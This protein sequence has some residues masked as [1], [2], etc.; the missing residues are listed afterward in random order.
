MDIQNEKEK[1]Q[2]SGIN[3]LLKSQALQTLMEKWSDGSFEEFMDDWKWIFSYSKRYKKAIIF[4]TLLGI[5][6][7]TLSLGSSVVSKYMID[8]IVGK[9]LDKLWLLALIMVSST[10][11]SLVFSSLVSR[12]STKISIQVGND[13][14]A[15]IFSRIVSADWMALHHYP[16]GDLLNRFNS[17][18]G[19]VSGNAIGWLP[20]VIIHT[21]TFLST[22]AVILY[23]DV[24]MAFI[25]LLSAP[26]LLLAS[27]WVLRKAREYRQRVMEMN[28]KLMTFEVDTFY[29]LDTI[30]SFGVTEKYGRELGKWQEKY[31]HHNLEYNLFSIKTNILTTMISTAVSLAAF[32]YC[33]F[34]L[35]TDAIS[36]GTMTLFLQQR[37]ALSGQFNALVGIVPGM[38]N[39]SVSAHRIREIVD[40]PREELNPEAAAALQDH[41]ADG[42]TV[43]MDG[44]NF[45]YEEHSRVITDSDFIARPGEIV[46]LVGPSGEGKTTMIR[47][48]LGLIHPEGGHVT[49]TGSDG[50]AL[51]VSADLRQFFSYVPQGNTMLAGTVAE[52][53]RMV[54]EDATDEEIIDAL[55]AACAWD[56]VSKLPDNIHSPVGERGRGFSEGQ[57]QRIAIARALLRDAPVMLLDEATSALDVTTERQV[58]KNIIRQ[59]P[60]KTCIVTTHRPSVLNLC[61]RVYRV[62][63][64]QVRELSEAESS[65]M[66]MDF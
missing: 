19:T 8:I 20:N 64:T 5:F 16:N 3:R 53:M 39:S 1:K 15:D 66:A 62:M 21:Y 17:D 57:A 40:L 18:V 30:K 56:F 52:N 41:A 7:S 44:V 65:R 2:Y 14:Q 13:I 28:S 60:N 12:I 6:S 4:Y 35:W 32:G 36:Y 51:D 50:Q 27:R 33:L 61:Q 58:L 34:R 10:V 54:R 43:R 49:L 26:F 47:L 29:N 46:A 11:F 48:I 42:L 22:F 23:Y 55:K 59:H 31:K 37:S 9:Q 45:A 38:L 63:Q 24:T 25:A